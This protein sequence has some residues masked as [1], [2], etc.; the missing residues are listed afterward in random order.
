MRGKRSVASWQQQRVDQVA[1]GCSADPDV[2]HRSLLRAV[3]A[4]G[5]RHLVVKE[6][7]LH[8]E[9]CAQV[10]AQTCAPPVSCHSRVQM[11]CPTLA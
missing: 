1:R 5:G 2:A 9:A 3:L 7:Q 4:T 6:P 8:G 10:T 11:L